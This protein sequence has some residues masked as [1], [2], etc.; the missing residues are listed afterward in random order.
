VNQTDL[1]TAEDLDAY[2]L[3]PADIRR[4]PVP[5]YT[6]SD[7]RTYWLLADLAPWLI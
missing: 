7:G 3:S 2:G 1:I 6:D 5:E 4:W